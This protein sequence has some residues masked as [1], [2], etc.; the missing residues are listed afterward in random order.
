MR[1]SFSMKIWE[2]VGKLK[3]GSLKSD[4]RH[5]IHKIRGAGVVLNAPKP[6]TR[7]GCGGMR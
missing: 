7:A 6:I 1:R 4:H 5:Q 2:L 3:I